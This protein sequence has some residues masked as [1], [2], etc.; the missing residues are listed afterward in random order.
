MVTSRLSIFE[1]HTALPG[2]AD[3]DGDGVPNWLEEITDSDALNAESFP[4][5]KDVVRAE[6]NT[7]DALLYDGPGAFTEEIIQRFLFDIDGSAS[8]TS[9]ERS[10]FV[11][12]SVEYFLDL[13]EK[14]GLPAVEL[15]VDETVSRSTV[16]S[17]FVSAMQRFS[18]VDTPIDVLVF[19]VFSK[20]TS[21]MEDAQRSR[22]VL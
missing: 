17:R 15:S 4:Y 7:A 9:E 8:V 11:D 22:I 19:E 16:L 21:V 18:D 5:N 13:V 14:K 20:N 2:K 1:T 3:S 6:Q 12:E 10:R